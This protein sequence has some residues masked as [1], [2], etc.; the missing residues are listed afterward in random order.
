MVTLP[1]PPPPVERTGDGRGLLFH[2][3][4]GQER[5][6]AAAE[7]FV[8][9]IAGTQSGKTEI[10]PPWLWREMRRR[11]PG[12]YFVVTPTFPMLELKALPKFLHLFETLCGL[13]RYR[14]SPSRRF[15]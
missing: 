3:P 6:L 7:R 11:G 12:D 10:G 5:T 8:A 1:N 13:G 2:L 4:A 9:A 15:K 14:S